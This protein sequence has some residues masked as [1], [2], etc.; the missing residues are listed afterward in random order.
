M[1]DGISENYLLKKT[2]WNMDLEIK[3][4]LTLKWYSKLTKKGKLIACR[5]LFSFRVCSTCFNLT[6]WSKIKGYQ[7]AA[8][9]YKLMINLPFVYLEFSWHNVSFSLY[10]G[11]ASPFQSCPCPES[12]SSRSP[13]GLLCSTNKENYSVI[14]NKRKR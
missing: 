1:P 10:A 8:F 14:I 11:P 12:W 2:T 9:L 13:Q 6:T 3:S 5:I 4:I 7:N